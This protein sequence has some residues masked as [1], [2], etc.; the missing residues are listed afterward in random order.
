M[1]VQKFKESDALEEKFYQAGLEA[2]ETIGSQR[3]QFFSGAYETYALG[4]MIYDTG[5]SPLSNAIVRTI[6]R[7]TFKEIFDAFIAGGTFEAYLTVFR[8]IFGEDVIVEFTV[9]EPGKLNIDITATGL[10]VYDLLSRYI[11]DNEYFFDEVINY[12]SDNIAT[13]GVKGFETQ[14]EVE[15]MLRELIPAGIFTAISLTI[16]EEE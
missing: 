4:E 14:Y 11:V 1:A 7:E 16:G 3:D 15:Q 12:D 10:E 6:F 2:M 9:P 8:K 13:Q 5:R